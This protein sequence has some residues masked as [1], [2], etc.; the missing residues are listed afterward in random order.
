MQLRENNRPQQCQKSEYECDDQR[1]GLGPGTIQSSTTCS[2]DVSND[3]QEKNHA[4]DAE[5]IQDVE[6]CAVGRETKLI[7][8]FVGIPAEPGKQCDRVV[9]HRAQRTAPEQYSAR[10]SEGY[11]RA[12]HPSKMIQEDVTKASRDPA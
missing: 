6:V 2:K 1:S 8:T 3:K 12:S 5:V 4:N 10:T 11:V 9:E 7:V